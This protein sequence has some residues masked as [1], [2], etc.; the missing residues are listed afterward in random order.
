MH[1]DDLLI[2]QY[3][4]FT[5]FYLYLNVKNVYIES[6]FAYIIYKF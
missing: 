6:L 4:L 5:I 3:V 1:L 2:E